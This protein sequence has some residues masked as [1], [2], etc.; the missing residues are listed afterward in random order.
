M[1]AKAKWL[2]AQ[3]KKNDG[4]EDAWT[5]QRV[6]LCLYAEFQATAPVAKKK[7]KTAANAPAAKRGKMAAAVRE[8]QDEEDNEAP[9]TRSKRRKTTG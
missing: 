1:Q 8:E 4:D 7:G 6:Q 9:Q 5:A 3:A 2:N